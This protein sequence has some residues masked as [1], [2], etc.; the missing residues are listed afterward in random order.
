MAGGLSKF[1]AK[2]LGGAP[3][4]GGGDQGD[5][6]PAAEEYV[7]YTIR[8][9]P[10]QDGGQWIT[11]AVIEKRFADG[12]KEHRFIR[13]DM[14]PGRE[15]AASASLF[16]ARQIIDMMGDDIFLTEGD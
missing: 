16:K 14:Y 5:P 6:E 9:V 15:A 7:G 2:L 3:K 8:P 13:A 12:V 4:G 1:M 10:F 11:S